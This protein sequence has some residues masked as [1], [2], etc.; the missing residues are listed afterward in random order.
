MAKR[1]FIACSNYKILIAY[2]WET[3]IS[4][5]IYQLF[6]Y[7]VEIED[8]YGVKCII[9]NNEHQLKLKAKIEHYLSRRNHE[10]PDYGISWE[11]SFKREQVFTEVIVLGKE[12]GF[13]CGNDD[14]PIWSKK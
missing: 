9:Y 12:M 8:D 13:Y 1:G 14:N 5:D 11:Q 2:N 4:K 3:K 7:E 6:N 10:K